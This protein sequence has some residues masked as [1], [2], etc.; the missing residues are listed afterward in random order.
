AD[1]GRDRRGALASAGRRNAG[2]RRAA[3]GQVRGIAIDGRVDELDRA[4]LVAD[5]AA[6]AV[7]GRAIDS[8]DG[9]IAGDGAVRQGGV[10]EV[11]KAAAIAG[12]AAAGDRQS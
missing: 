12:D 4:G 3:T 7:D 1:G 9:V 11:V 10:A 2:I 5:S 6:D 8:A